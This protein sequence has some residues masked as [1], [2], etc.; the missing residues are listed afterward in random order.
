MALD[1]ILLNSIVDNL[2]PYLPMRINKI[3]SVGKNEILINI[4][5]KLK[6][7]RLLISNDANANNLNM[8]VSF[9]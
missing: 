7:Q 1:G 6:N 5:T 2:H 3:Y 9:V 4:H 8:I